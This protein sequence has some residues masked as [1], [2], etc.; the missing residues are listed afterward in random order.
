MKSIIII[1]GVALLAVTC[2]AAPSQETQVSS[3]C[4]SKRDAMD[5]SVASLLMISNPNLRPFTSVQ[6]L[7]EQY[8]E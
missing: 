8:C 3:E 5:R 2:A 4:L 1:I 6:D 7:D